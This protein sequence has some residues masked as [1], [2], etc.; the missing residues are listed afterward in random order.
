MSAAVRKATRQLFDRERRQ[1][2]EPGPASADVRGFARR[3][4]AIIDLIRSAG[5][6]VLSRAQHTLW[7]L[8]DGSLR[9]VLGNRYVMWLRTSITGG[10]AQMEEDEVFEVLDLLDRAGVSAWLVGGWGVDALL[11]YRSRRHSDL[12][13]VVLAQDGS[14][15]RACAALDSAGYRI[16][17]QG[18]VPGAGMPRRILL[19]NGTGK[20]VDLHPVDASMAAFASVTSPGE[21]DPAAFATG[22]L[23][24][25]AVPCV[26]VTCQVSLKSYPGAHA[27]DGRDIE[28][29]Q[30]LTTNAV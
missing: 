20:S 30:R 3:L 19:D 11:R 17:D 12:D 24:G 15:E 25:R 5:H 1:R 21:L 4:H 29:L 14:L 18:E 13:L 2:T 22:V 16:V 9:P 7:R 6:A 23:A 10:L 8:E 26:S 27:K 28:Q